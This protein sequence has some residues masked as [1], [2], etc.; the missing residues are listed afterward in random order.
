MTIDVL[1]SPPTLRVDPSLGKRGVKLWK[2]SP[3][4]FKRGERGEFF[5]IG[6]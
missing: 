3:S 4:L 1:N 6:G 2:I 5:L